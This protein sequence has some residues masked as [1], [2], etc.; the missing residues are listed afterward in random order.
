MRQRKGMRGLKFGGKATLLDAMELLKG[1]WEANARYGTSSGILRCWRKANI[2]LI[3]WET[4]IENTVGRDS[5][6]DKLKQISKEDRK[7]L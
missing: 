5:V 2:L 3:A 1:I 4:E 6:P 7:E